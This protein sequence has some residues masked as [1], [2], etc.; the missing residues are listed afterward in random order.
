[1]ATLD[2]FPAVYGGDNVPV[3]SWAFDGLPLDGVTVV[4]KF[5]YQGQSYHTGTDGSGLTVDLDT[6]TIFLTPFAAPSTNRNTRMAYD[7][8]LDGTTYF[9]GYVPL[10][11]DLAQ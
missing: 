3:S 5:S 2:N 11:K 9:Y 7:L 6:N 1:M 4:I 8:K 10:L